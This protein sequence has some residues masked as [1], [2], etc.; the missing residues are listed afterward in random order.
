MTT[1]PLPVIEEPQ[2]ASWRLIATLGG[3]GALAGLLIVLAYVWTQP[4]IAAHRATVLQAAIE[5]VLKQPDHADTLYLHGDALVATL[6]AGV[7]GAT[8]ERIYR[9]YD[10]AGKAIGY[11][12]SASEPGFADNITVLFG[13]DAAADQV[14]A[15]KVL[16]SKETPGLGD[17]IERPAFTDQ[18]MGR[19][20]PLKGVKGAAPAGD[21][22]AIAMITG[23]TISSRTIIDEMNTAIARW[24]PLID[25]YQREGGKS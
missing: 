16:G 1:T 13:Y 3:A 23:A 14:L 8:L 7:D 21:P 12:I 15:M 5:E 4:R 10:A 22:S 20:A 19:K 11:A 2:V 17:K 6:P 9:G 24:E 25:R 18:F